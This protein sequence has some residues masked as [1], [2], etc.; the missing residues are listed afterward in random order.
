LPEGGGEM[1]EAEKRLKYH[2]QADVMVVEFKDSKILD[3]TVIQEVGNEL[4][5]LVDKQFRPKMLLDF[6]NVDYLYSAALGK[7]ITLHKRVR[8]KKGQLRFCAIKPKIY[9][10]FR[11][12]KLDKIFEIHENQEKALADF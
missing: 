2:E 10:V 9:D 5:G 6:T 11:I 1:T 4:F 12:T 7:L 3:E 8:E